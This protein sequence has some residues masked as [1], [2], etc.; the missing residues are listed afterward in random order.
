VP[1]LQDPLSNGLFP[2]KIAIDRFGASTLKGKIV[3]GVALTLAPTCAT[4]S[5]APD[6]Y[7]R[8]I[9]TETFR[10][11]SPYV[12]KAQVAGATVNDK[13]TQTVQV[14]LASPSRRGRVDSWAAVVE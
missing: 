14:Q 10:S 6:A 13:T 11:A 7:G 1:R 4:F 8:T 5:Q 3:P 12:L 9:G 2:Q